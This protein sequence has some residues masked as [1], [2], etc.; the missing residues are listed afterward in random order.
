MN[1]CVCILAL[2]LIIGV[3]HFSKVYANTTKKGN[4]SLKN[5]SN[6]LKRHIAYF[7]KGENFPPIAGF[8][9]TNDGGCATIPIRFN[10]TSTGTGLTFHWDFGDPNSGKSDTSSLINPQHTF[11]G[12]HGNGVQTYTVTLIASADSGTVSSTY[13]S[14][15]TLQQ[16][17][18]TN[19][20]GSGAIYFNNLPYFTSCTNQPSLFQFTNK[21]T[22][23]NV[24][25]VIKWGDK[26]SDFKSTNFTTISHNYNPGFYTLFFSVTGLN[27][28]VNTQTYYVFVGTAPQL[29]PINVLSST[30]CN[31][32][33]LTVQLN[34]LNNNSKGTIYQVTYSDSTTVKYVAPFDTLMH[35]FKKGSFNQVA[36]IN[37]QTFNNAYYA[38]V[39]AL[40]PCGAVTL[41][42]VPIYVSDFQPANFSIN[43]Q[44]TSATVN[45]TETLVYANNLGYTIASDGTASKN[46]IVWKIAPSTGYSA[47]GTLGSD[48]GSNDSQQWMGGNVN[49]TVNF[50]RPGNYSI[51]LKAGNYSCGADSQ[52]MSICI[53]SI[54]VASFK[55]SSNTICSGTTVQFKNTS[56]TAMCGITQ[57]VWSVDLVKSDSCATTS[58]YVFTDSTAINSVNPQILFTNAG[59]YRVGLISINPD[60]SKSAIFYQ[61]IN[62]LNIPQ[63]KI[64]TIDTICYGQS[65]TPKVVITNCHADTIKSYQ[66]SFAGGDPLSSTSTTPNVSFNTVGL[67]KIKVITNSTCSFST[68]SV[69]VYVNPNLAVKSPGDRILCSTT[70]MDTVYFQASLPGENFRWRNDNPAI[71][72]DT[73]GKGKFIAFVPMNKTNSSLT[74]NI[75]VIPF[76]NN[77]DGPSVSFSITVL[78]FLNKPAVTSPLNLCLNNV[79]DTLHAIT[80][81]GNK[82][83]WYADSTLRNK[84][85]GAPEPPTT[86]AQTLTYYVTQ[87]N[88]LG[89]ES[90]KS[91]IVVIV[92]PPIE[93]NT[94]TSDQNLC[95]AQL[96]QTLTSA[97]AIKGGRN[98]YSYQW[99]L[100]T[101]SGKTWR[102]AQNGNSENYDPDIF[103]GLEKFRR[104]VS[105]GS[106][107]STSNEVSISI[108]N[109][110]AGFNISANNQFVAKNTIP[111]IINGN[112]ASGGTGAFS[113]QWQISLNN[114]N[115][116]DIA[117]AN[118]ISYQ[119][120]AALSNVFY[121][122]ITTSG[123]CFAV[124]SFVEIILKNDVVIPNAFT[125][126]G[127]GINDV[128]NI[129]GFEDDPTVHL[130]VYNRYGSKVLDERDKLNPWDGTYN[131][132]K[133]P[134]GTYYYVLFSKDYKTSGYV[135]IIY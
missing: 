101:D 38:S 130:M 64:S 65:F 55:A 43:P 1:K 33:P 123:M 109:E 110:I 112:V 77:C 31:N 99:Q 114:L 117:G 104:L 78:P 119:P 34:G 72:L 86:E 7:K 42:T 125:P 69:N 74:A 52:K 67:H 118:N 11:I 60:Q 87:A 122:R 58:G 70:T 26:T 44:V 103:A 90:E 18:S 53:D 25:Y 71:G 80:A 29:N 57:Y 10:N 4:L 82:L 21:S 94:I 68:D 30:I 50:Q 48:N 98:N 83:I 115:W 126:N 79:A 6:A 32:Q 45:N 124:S 81:T 108:E 49:P 36:K 40:N 23:N 96:P 41:N 102:N 95:Y 47:V 73:S 121:R 62:V 105:S 91:S 24:A 59:V 39:T 19:L 93:N 27:G 88:I 22:T 13:T 61:N 20:D 9:H 46:K 12:N 54:P 116:T 28:C 129:K 75:T 120:G 63:V 97:T 37:T 35:Y 89:C 134:P 66:W 8:T 56:S 14:Q 127:D 113:Y 132:K 92:N 111:Q 135:A 51:V 106:C 16:T 107:S 128:W 133:L 84:L 3:G 2:C 15:I 100:S 5:L 131:E 17:P 85:A 76:F